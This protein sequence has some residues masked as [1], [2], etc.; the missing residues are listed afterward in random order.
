MI[1]TNQDP[2][3][4]GLSTDELPRPVL[5]LRHEVPG[6]LAAVGVLACQPQFL[7]LLQLSLHLR[8]GVVQPDLPTENGGASPD[9][10]DA[11]DAESEGEDGRK[12]ETPPNHYTDGETERPHCRTVEL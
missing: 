5:R 11:E 4:V 1:H 3:C 10:E 8:G 6:V 7:V 12:K 2:S 9:E